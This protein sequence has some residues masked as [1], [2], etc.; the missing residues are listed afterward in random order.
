MALIIAIILWMP[1]LPVPVFCF[2]N[3]RMKADTD[4]P[5]LLALRNR[6]IK[7]RFPLFLAKA[8]ESVCPGVEYLPNW[9]LDLIAEYLAAVEKAEVTRLIINMPPRCLKSITISVAWPAYLLGK[10]PSMRILCASYAQALSLKHSLDTRL[11]LQ[12]DWYRRTFPQ[13][14]IAA[15]ENEK[16]RFVTS[17]R[18][19]RFATSVGGTVTGMGGDVLIVDDPLNPL[20]ASSK[21]ERAQANQWFDQ[22]FST[23]LDDKQKGRIVIVMQ[24]LHPEDLSGHLLAKG[25]WEHLCL[26]AFAENRHRVGFAGVQKLREAGEALHP[27]RENELL[28]T[29][30]RGELGSLAFAAQ[31]QQ[32]P[33]PEGG[34]M[35][36]PQWVR[37]YDFAPGDFEQVIQSW[38]TGIKSD[39]R[40][41]ASACLT[42]GV[43]GNCYY[44]LHALQLR[45]EYPE[46]KKAVLM[47]AENF[48]PD[49]VLIEDK[50]SGQSLLQDLRRESKL[51]II[52]VLPKKDKVTRVAR[53]SSL[54]EA[55][56]LY[57]PHHASWLALFESELFA[58]PAAAH[59]DQV[60]ALSQ[61]LEWL[62]GKI[63]NT[64]TIRIL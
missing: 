54:I 45:A 13:T 63:K 58:F 9:H 23:R 39:P 3:R 14:E 4:F 35:I 50:A 12:Q 60:D 24:R 5:S 61:G 62:V 33:V 20:Q 57:L 1:C 28:L 7:E 43:K 11:L 49:T 22:T 55:G 36:S 15:G 42:I 47:Q 19:Y 41:D 6:M 46:L 29:R 18:G 37:R 44:L 10:N 25:G 27:A 53:V 48:A 56:R 16:H 31:Y 38:D 30:A 8:F 26:P 52:P 2:Q 32:N 51:A 21:T 17:A 40:H 64:P 59:D 34:N